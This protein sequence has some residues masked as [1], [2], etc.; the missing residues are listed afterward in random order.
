MPRVIFVMTYNVHSCAQKEP[1]L[2]PGFT[3][4]GIYETWETG[5]LVDGRDYYLAFYR[6]A[7]EPRRYILMA[8]WQFDSQVRLLR[9]KDL[10]EAGEDPSP[11]SFLND[12]WNRG[13]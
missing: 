11:L 12:R 4:G 13:G 7:R 1:I 10:K 9:E 3:C 2:R 5:L 6:A 8:G